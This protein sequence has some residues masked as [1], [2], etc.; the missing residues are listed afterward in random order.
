MHHDIDQMIWQWMETP[1]GVLD[2]KTSE[3]QRIINRGTGG[4]YPLE[5]ERTHDAGILGEMLIIVPNKTALKCRPISCQGEKKNHGHTK[6]NGKG[7]WLTFIFLH[8]RKKQTNEKTRP[9]K[10]SL[11]IFQTVNPLDGLLKQ[12]CA[13]FQFQFFFNAGAVGFD[14]LDSQM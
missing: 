12:L 6:P 8:E 4:P 9:S 7:H 10:F 3:N 14:G 1:K 5:S 13:V 11:A 2:P